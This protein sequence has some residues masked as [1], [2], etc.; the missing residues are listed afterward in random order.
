MNLISI[1][2]LQQSN[3]NIHIFLLCDT[4]TIK[5]LHVIK[6]RILD[7]ADDII[8]V[9]IKEGSNSYR[10]RFIKTSMRNHING[11]FLYLDGDTLIRGD[12]NPIFETEASFSAAA[13]HSG[14]GCPSEM[15]TKEAMDFKKLNW[16]FPKRFYANGGVL[17]F[18][19]QDETFSFSEL[20]HQ[21]WLEYTKKT[22]SFYDQ[23]S[24]NSAL[25]DSNIN[26]CWMDTV[27]NAQVHSRPYTAWGAKVWHLYYS[28][29]D[30]SPRT[31]L[32]FGLTQL[33][34][35]KSF[36][37]ES[38]QKLCKRSHPWIITN[39][40][41]WFAVKR[42]YSSKQILDHKSWKRL[43]LADDYAGAMRVF[44]HNLLSKFRRLLP[45]R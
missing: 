18:S 1:W 41:D 45:R 17:F 3:P 39:F 35:N 5:A 27:Y 7:N 30:P 15:P 12:L 10:N 11:P 4:E 21:K 31:I 34:Q 23:P 6:H 24:L 25:N 37:K 38:L 32:D 16:P 14:A 40:I 43:W 29:Q 22:E 19:G 33:R 13:N 42:L 9:N 20:W 26:F 28:D 36:N 2:S 44:N 8:Q